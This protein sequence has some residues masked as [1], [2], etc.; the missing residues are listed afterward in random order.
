[1][2]HP[3]VQFVQIIILRFERDLMN[4]FSIF[5]QLL[6]FLWQKKLWW[7]LPMVIVLVLFGLLLVFAQ[8]SGLA[9]FI[10]TLF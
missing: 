4:K 7:M 9:P 10:Y 6:T 3:S 5:G 2:V 1:M 8:G